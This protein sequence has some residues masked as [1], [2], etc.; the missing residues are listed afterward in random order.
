MV[1]TTWVGL[2]LG[3]CG[4]PEGFRLDQGCLELQ[5][6]LDGWGL[7]WRRVLEDFSLFAFY[8]SWQQGCNLGTGFLHCLLGDEVGVDSGGTHD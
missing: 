3:G 2:E 8:F 6:Y 4:I 5:S 1:E 7:G